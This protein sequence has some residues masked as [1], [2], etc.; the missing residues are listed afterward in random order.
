MTI[1]PKGA[2]MTPDPQREP[3]S[4]RCHRDPAEVTPRHV[5]VNGNYTTYY[6]IDLN[7]EY[8]S[9]AWR[10]KPRRQD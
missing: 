7:A 10:R 1:H 3:A 5:N 9:V 4:P 6:R 8:A 2:P